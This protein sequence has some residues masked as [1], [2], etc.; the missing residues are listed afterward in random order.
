MRFSPLVHAALLMLLIGAVPL[1]VSAFELALTLD[2]LP[3]SDST[4]RA[5]ADGVGRL[6]TALQ[7]AQVP[8]TGFSVCASAAQLPALQRQWRAAGVEI[9]NHS[10]RHRDYNRLSPAEW[11]ADLRACQQSLAAQGETPRF[12]RFPQ[13][14]SGDTPAKKAHAQR[15]LA[16]LA[17][18]PAPVSVDTHD[19]ML[20]ASYR[21]LGTPAQRARVGA[22]LRDHVLR[23]LRHARQTA[24]QR[25]GRDAAQILLLHANALV[26]E[27]LPALLAAL[28]DEGAHFVTLAQALNDPVYALPDDY[29]GSEG[30]SWLYR[31]TPAEPGRADWDRAEAV[32]LRAALDVVAAAD[33]SAALTPAQAYALAAATTLRHHGS[34]GRERV[35]H[36]WIPPQATTARLPFVV[37]LDGD[38]AFPLIQAIVRHYIDRGDVAPLAVVGISH[39]GAD[40]D[41]AT[42]RRAR[43]RDYT[44]SYTLAGGY[45]EA[46]QAESGNAAQFRDI[47]L[48]ELLPELAR[49]YPLDTDRATYVGHSYGGLFGSFVLATRPQAFRRYVLASPSLWYDD[50]IAFRL[51]AASPR[52]AADR[53]P[54]VF[55]AAGGLENP[56]MAADLNRYAAALAAHGLPAAALRARV[57]AD[58]THNSIFPTAFTTALRWFE[59]AR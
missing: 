43:S 13:L 14:H 25:Y 22:L 10:D 55:L 1:R 49:R 17:L 42:Y 20:A 7:Q 12:Y 45:G 23:S 38:Y 54:Q 50:G 5:A 41:L 44:P 24:Q 31:T 29:S 2:D 51:L 4:D 39:P 46:F 27:Q 3:W 28:R 30:L 48:D 40:T 15:E 36:V 37:A 52:F 35:A 33:R 26:A 9:A 58:D 19:W 47:V 34:D 6:I 11:S 59:G 32:R 18:R 57:L 21:E 53:A 16:V 56:V 8:V